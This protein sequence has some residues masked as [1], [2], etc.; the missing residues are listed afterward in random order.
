MH[1]TSL[2]LV[3][4]KNKVE[5][6]LDLHRKATAGRRKENLWKAY[7]EEENA[8]KIMKLN[9]FESV[10]NEFND[11]LENPEKNEF[12]ENEQESEEIDKLKKHENRIQEL[13]EEKKKELRQIEAELLDIGSKIKKQTQEG[14]YR[15]SF[16]IWNGEESD[17]DSVYA[18]ILKQIVNEKTAKRR[19]NRI[20]AIR[21][22]LNKREA[23]L[24]KLQQYIFVFE[25]KTNWKK[26]RKLWI[27]CLEY[28]KEKEEVL[29]INKKTKTIESN[30][31]IVYK[32]KK[33]YLNITFQEIAAAKKYIKHQLLLM[34][35]LLTAMPL[36]NQIFKNIKVESDEVYL[37]LKENIWLMNK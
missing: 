26:T 15:P 19:K 17:I 34:K 4:Q 21:K 12:T 28:K 14:N 33:P 31:V 6:L 8:F 32:I 16:M 18:D 3:K 5:R 35:L 25:S 10:V 11:F 24:K 27:N 37:R 22:H 20:K 36:D 23:Y 7:T 2:D 30:T 1:I 9:A 29:K 13:N